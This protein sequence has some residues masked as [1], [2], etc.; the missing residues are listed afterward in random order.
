MREN[1]LGSLKSEISLKLKERQIL[2]QEIVSLKTEIK[3]INKNVDSTKLQI[4]KED[5]SQI[6]KNKP[7][8]AAMEIQSLKE[9][10]SHHFADYK[11]HLCLKEKYGS[12]LKEEKELLE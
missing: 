2:I 1:N 5:K 9:E 8:R 3:R 6:R 4:S 12:R 11:V 7:T 10:I